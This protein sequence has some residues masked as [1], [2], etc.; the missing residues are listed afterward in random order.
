MTTTFL[1]TLFT[2]LLTA[3]V[4]SA[5]QELTWNGD[6]PRDSQWNGVSQKDPCEERPKGSK[7]NDNQWRWYKPCPPTSNPTHIPS[8]ETSYVPTTIQTYKPSIDTNTYNETMACKSQSDE[9]EGSR[10]VPITLL[11]VDL[12]VHLKQLMDEQLSVCLS[13]SADPSVAYLIIPSSE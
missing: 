9:L 1:G 10:V 11:L 7:S 13:S 5:R 6:Q 8:C 4:Q 12:L 2:L 3:T